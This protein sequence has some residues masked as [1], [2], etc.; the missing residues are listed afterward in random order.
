MSVQF[1]V[2]YQLLLSAFQS[3]KLTLNHYENGLMSLFMPNSFN[4]ELHARLP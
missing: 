2:V 1:I 4:L 3:V